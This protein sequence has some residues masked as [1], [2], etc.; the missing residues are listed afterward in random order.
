M[1]IQSRTDRSLPG[2]AGKRLGSALAGLHRPE[3]PA[4]ALGGQL[5][6]GRDG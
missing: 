6:D 5:V 4:P 3:W 2:R 1:K